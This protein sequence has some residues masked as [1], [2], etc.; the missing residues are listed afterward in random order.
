MA[1]TMKLHIIPLALILVM[2]MPRFHMTDAAGFSIDLIHRDSIQSPSLYSA[3]ERIKNALQRSYDR[4]KNLARNNSTQQPSTEII[5]DRGEY[6][7]KFSLGTPPVE[8]LAI[9]DTGSDLTWIQCKP[10]I[11]CFKQKSPIFDPK[12]S[13]TYKPVSCNTNACNALQRTSCDS[14]NDTCRYEIMY[15]DRSY[16]KGDLATETLTLGSNVSIRNVTI[17]CGHLD[18]GTFGAGSSG[19][20]GLGGGKVSLITQMGS[21]IQGKFSYCLVPFLGESSKPSKMNFGENVVVS[22]DGVVSTPIVAKTPSTFYFLTLEG[23]TVGEQRLDIDLSSS[24]SSLSDDDDDDDDIKASQEGNIII[25]SGTTLT[26]LPIELYYQVITAVRSQMVLREISDPQG[27]LN[28]CYLSTGD[29]MPQVPE[30][31][32]H[33]RGADVK[34]KSINTFVKTSQMSLCLAFAP[35]TSFAIYGNLAQMNFLVGYDLEKRTVSFKPT[36]CSKA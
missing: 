24:S 20:V 17:G 36:I 30:I 35:A 6:L 28:L 26:F 16:S 33:F 13:S 31:I 19:I 12:R 34:L 2:S 7:M 15:G 9:A 10:C 25:D 1:R 23:M 5:P 32:A 11:K 22:G 8:T 21:S 18:Q 3:S 14:S 4:A 29:A 27:L